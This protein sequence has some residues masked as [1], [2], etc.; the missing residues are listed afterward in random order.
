MQLKE[1]PLGAT[2]CNTEEQ[3]TTIVQFEAKLYRVS[4]TLLV[5]F[6]QFKEVQN[7]LELKLHPEASHGPTSKFVRE[8]ERVCYT[9]VTNMFGATTVTVAAKLHFEQRLLEAEKVATYWSE[10]YQQE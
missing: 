5:R 9:I 4:T 8:L 3:A 10:E 6:G 2:T 7:H 1:E